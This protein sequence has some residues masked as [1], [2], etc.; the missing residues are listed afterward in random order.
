MTPRSPT[1]GLLPPQRGFALI[2]AIVSA[3]IIGLMVAAAVETVGKSRTSQVWAADRVRGYELA[4]QL[5]AEI[6]SA[7]YSDPDEATLFGR[8]ISEVLGNRSD[9]DDVDDYHGLSESPPRLRDGSVLTGYSGWRRQVSVAHAL[10]SDTSQDAFLDSGAKRIVVTVYSPASKV[11][12]LHSI[13][14]V[15]VNR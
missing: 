6:T 8:E 14:T 3:M 15:T 10:P 2:E 5:M 13:R 9:F 1:P 4:S 7:P 11:A 12:E